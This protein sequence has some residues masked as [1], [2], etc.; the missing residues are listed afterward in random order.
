MLKGPDTKPQGSIIKKTDSK[1]TKHN[2]SQNQ[3]IDFELFQHT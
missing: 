3:I 2:E 1:N